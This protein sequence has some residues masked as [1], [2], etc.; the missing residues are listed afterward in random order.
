MGRLLI[1][2]VIAK[3]EESLKTLL[4]PEIADANALFDFFKGVYAV[5]KPLRCLSPTAVAALR[6]EGSKTIATVY[7]FDFAPDGKIENIRCPQEE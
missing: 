2:S 3:D 6:R 1:E 5:E 7:D 4:C